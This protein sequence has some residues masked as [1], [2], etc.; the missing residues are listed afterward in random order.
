MLKSIGCQDRGRDVSKR[1]SWAMPS[2]K[3]TTKGDLSSDMEERKASDDQPMPHPT[4]PD[5]SCGTQGGSG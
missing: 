5:H 3:K 4:L 1:L 2:A